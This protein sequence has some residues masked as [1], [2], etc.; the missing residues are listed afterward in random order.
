VHNA[1]IE[2]LQRERDEQQMENAILRRENVKLQKR[3][4]DLDRDLR[5]AHEREKNL[6]DELRYLQGKI[7][8]LEKQTQEVKEYELRI[9]ELEREISEYDEKLQECRKQLEDSRKAARDAREHHQLKQKELDSVQEEHRRLI[10]EYEKQTMSLKCQISIMEN[11]VKRQEEDKKLEDH[12]GTNT[13]FAEVCALRAA[14]V[15]LQQKNEEYRAELEYLREENVLFPFGNSYWPRAARTLQAE[16]EGTDCPISPIQG[17]ETT[18]NSHLIN[19]PSGTEKARFA[20]P[21]LLTCTS[22]HPTTPRTSLI[23][24]HRA[25][26]DRTF[27]AT[28][29]R[30]KFGFRNPARWS[31]QSTSQSTFASS[32]APTSPSNHRTSVFSPADDLSSPITLMSTTEPTSPG[33]KT[34]PH[35]RNPSQLSVYSITGRSVFSPDRKARASTHHVVDENLSIREDDMTRYTTDGPL[36]QFC[37]TILEA[38]NPEHTE[39]SSTALIHGNVAQQH[40]RRLRRRVSHESVIQLSNGMDVHTLKCRPS[41]LVLGQFGLPVPAAASPNISVVT[42]HPTL[43]RGPVSGGKRGSVI[44]RD[45]IRGR[46]TNQRAVTTALEERSAERDQDSRKSKGPLGLGKLVSWMPWGNNSNKESGPHSVA[47]SNA[48]AAGASPSASPRLSP[49]DNTAS[50]TILALS[51]PNN[52]TAEPSSS[53]TPNIT[54]QPSLSSSLTSLS[55]LSAATSISHTSAPTPSKRDPVAAHAAAMKAMFRA[56]GVNQPGIVPG[57]ETKK[58]LRGA[59]SKVFVEEQIV[60]SVREAMREVLEEVGE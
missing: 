56:P 6:D 57:F 11:K 9:I 59:P 26:F 10:S 33:W 27:T 21:S 55:A 2:K 34:M 58:K 44:L 52:D 4:N 42:A 19:F 35:K 32:S 54:A 36:S 47:L 31:V 46:S 38:E 22:A 48:S 37:D 51:V 53:T 17:Q 43:L 13:L 5:D 24:A 28:T 20:L 50:S 60:G 1:E 18:V 7:N 25:A 40:G 3:I 15:E 8:E 14:Y 39:S 41:Q 23:H 49:A 45:T 30:E 16:L 12:Y 29:P